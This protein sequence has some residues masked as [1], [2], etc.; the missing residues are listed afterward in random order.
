M[1]MM[2]NLKLLLTTALMLTVANHAAAQQYEAWPLGNGKTDTAIVVFHYTEPEDRG[3]GSLYTKSEDYLHEEDSVVMMRG[4]KLTLKF[5]KEITYQDKSFFSMFTISTPDKRP[6]VAVTDSTGKNYYAD[7][8]ELRFSESNA[9]GTENPIA[10]YTDFKGRNYYEGAFLIG[11]LFFLWMAWRLSRR[12]AK[13]GLKKNAMG[14]LKR[15]NWLIGLLLFI[16]PFFAFITII[17]EI[18]AVRELG[19]DC[20][21]WLNGAYVGDFQRFFNIFLL[22]LAV[23]WQYKTID[24]YATGMEAFLCSSEA[25]PRQQ[26]LYNILIAVVLFAGL[27]FVGICLYGWVSHTVGTVV[28]YIAAIAGIGYLL[29]S[30]FAMF[31]QMKQSAGWILTI[32]YTLFVILW[33]VGTILMVGILIWQILKIIIPFIVLMVFGK[34]IPALGLDKPSPPMKWYDSAGGVHDSQMAR[35]L[36]NKALESYK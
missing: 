31:I 20:C 23:R 22:F 1:Y 11:I 32:L 16:A 35:D 9:E 17:L 30:L 28:I 12:A 18:D 27:A 24:A 6:L 36:R 14:T 25:V 5:P 19:E 21:W 13:I 29:Y 10:K 15:H 2:K 3:G 4:T 26:M 7:P 33:A 34:M 8:Y